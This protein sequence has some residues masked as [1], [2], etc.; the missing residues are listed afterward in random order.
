MGSY[1]WM[2]LWV[3]LL[4]ALL[5]LAAGIKPIKGTYRH[6]HNVHPGH[7]LGWIKKK[8]KHSILRYSCRE[9]C[10]FMQSYCESCTKPN[11]SDHDRYR[12]GKGSDTNGKGIAE[13]REP[14]GKRTAGRL[15]HDWKRN[16]GRHVHLV[17][18]IRKRIQGKIHKVSCNAVCK[19][20][21]AQCILLLI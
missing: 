17:H 21:K 10:H 15:D 19:F 14:E 3:A 7:A 2:A 20:A 11:W 9:A 5:A 16:K 18:N 13:R 6:K 12:I 8:A 1:K 4:V